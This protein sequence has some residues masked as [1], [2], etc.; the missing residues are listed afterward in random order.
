MRQSASIYRVL[1]LARLI[2]VATRIR[3]RAPLVTRLLEVC[4]RLLDLAPRDRHPVA[5]Y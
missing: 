3:A 4:E 5:P 1:T 2:E